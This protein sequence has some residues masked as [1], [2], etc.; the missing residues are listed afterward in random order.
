MRCP[1]IIRG[2]IFAWLL[3]SFGSATTPPPRSDGERTGPSAI[4]TGTASA[5]LGEECQGD[6]YSAWG[7]PFSL[8]F[9]SRE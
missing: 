6:G 3:A 1:V 5:E 4:A 7:S 2:P 8:A 9:D